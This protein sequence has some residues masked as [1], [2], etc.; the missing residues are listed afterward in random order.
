MKA[1][2]KSIDVVKW[3]ILSP[4]SVSIIL[5]ISVF[6]WIEPPKWEVENCNVTWSA[7]TRGKDNH[8]YKRNWFWGKRDGSR[9]REKESKDARENNLVYSLPTSYQSIILPLLPCQPSFILW[10]GRSSFE[11][12]VLDCQVNEAV[13][14]EGYGG[15]ERS[16][17]HR[18]KFGSLSRGCGTSACAG[19]DAE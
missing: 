7:W 12:G 16:G 8:S 18:L 14:G 5:Y 4:S 9:R 2:I 10:I 3:M 1:H 19:D 13:F 11:H 6:I 15:E 17:H